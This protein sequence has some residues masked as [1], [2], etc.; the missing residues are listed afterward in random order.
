MK[1]NNVNTKTQSGKTNKSR[2]VGKQRAKRPVSIKQLAQYAVAYFGESNFNS[3]E[4]VTD[5]IEVKAVLPADVNLD[6]V[7][8]SLSRLSERKEVSFIPVA[9]DLVEDDF[10]ILTILCYYKTY[11]DKTTAEQLTH[12]INEA[13]GGACVIRKLETSVK[14]EHDAVLIRV[15]DDVKRSLRFNSF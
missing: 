15:Y 12:E 9:K 5:Y 14:N 8:S 13:I 10:A 2:G 4:K 6:L 3:D 7:G 1:K 11:G